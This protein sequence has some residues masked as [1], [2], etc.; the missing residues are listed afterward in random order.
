MCYDNEINSY[1]FK[2]RKDNQIKRMGYRIE[3]EEIENALNTIDFI[4]EAAVI[5]VNN[6]N[7]QSK[8]IACLKSN[9]LDEN[10]INTEIRR[11]LP[12][13]MMPDKIDFFDSLPKNQN[14]K[15][16]RLSLK[17]NYNS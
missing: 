10:K 13:Y 11:Y 15:I 3:L 16:D 9:I 12:Q 8:I 6:E 17:T 1:L 5:Y 2:G 7:N 14:G 4:Q